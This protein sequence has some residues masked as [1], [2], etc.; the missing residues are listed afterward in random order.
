MPCQASSLG[1]RDGTT[2]FPTPLCREPCA[3]SLGMSTR[4][5][6]PTV[7]KEALAFCSGISKDAITRFELGHGPHAHICGGVSL[8]EPGTVVESER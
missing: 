8:V 6:H 7:T 3:R 5:C 1:A 4:R 2:R